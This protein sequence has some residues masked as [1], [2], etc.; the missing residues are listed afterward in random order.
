MV[1]GGTVGA[2]L[3]DSSP[4]ARLMVL[5]VLRASAAG[6][7]VGLATVLVGL[8]LLSTAWL[9]LSGAAARGL[10]TAPVVRL[11]ATT[12]A[13]PMVLAPPLFSRDGWSYAAQGELAARGWSPYDVGPGVLHGPVIEAVDPRWMSTPSP[14]GPVVVWLGEHIARATSDP[15]VMVVLH[16]CVALAGL[17]LV[18]WAVARMAG[19]TGVPDG[20]ALAAALASPAVLVNGVA[21]LHNDLLM[22][23]LMAVALVVA[24]ERGWAPGALV[25][26][27]AAAV[28]APGVLMVVPVAMVS[29]SAA[30]GACARVARVAASAAVAGVTLLACGW[31]TGWGLGWVEALAVPGTVVTP[32]SL[33]SVGGSALDALAA[34]GGWETGAGTFRAAARALALAAL[35]GT[36]VALVLRGVVGDRAAAVR[37][38]TLLLGAAALLMPVVHLWYALWVLPFA[39]VGRWSRGARVAWAAGGVVLALAAPLD[40]SL[41]GAYVL[42]VVTAVLAAA[43]AVGVLLSEAGRRRLRLIG[44]TAA[45]EAASQVPS[46]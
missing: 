45:P 13:L 21:G 28:K 1:A 24:G 34:A 43:V 25:V 16:R 3:P 30:A 14:Y 26:G 9:A 38:A 32:L 41:H 4:V 12:W 35:A 33:P 17:A 18:A 27:L 7:M 8:W 31:L 6:R 2:T 20:F 42:V 5:E 37:S 11:A 46:A 10:L 22:V 23:G 36:G 15:W 29:L 19:W 40:P 44:G 39:A